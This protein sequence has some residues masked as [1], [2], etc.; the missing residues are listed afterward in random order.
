[1]DDIPVTEL[2]SGNWFSRNIFRQ[3]LLQETTHMYLFLLY[4]YI[5]IFIM[6]AYK[7]KGVVGIIFFAWKSCT[8]H[9]LL[10]N[11]YFEM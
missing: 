2:A 10:Q 4:T 7:Y 6:H 9:I 11:I 8:Q 3:L 5:Y 1:M